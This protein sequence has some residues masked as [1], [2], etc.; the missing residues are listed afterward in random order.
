MMNFCD[1]GCPRLGGVALLCLTTLLLIGAKPPEGNWPQASGPSGDWTSKKKA[2]VEWSV[3]RNE[4][5]AWTA[6]LP[7]V[8]QGGIAVWGDHLFLTT[9]RPLPNAEASKEGSDIV[10]YCLSAAS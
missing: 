8:G 5:I 7:E 3:S 10:G 9:M 4:N 1:K 6:T 2:P